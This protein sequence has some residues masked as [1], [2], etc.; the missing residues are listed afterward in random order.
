M[1]DRLRRR[2]RKL[3]GRGAGIDDYGVAALGGLVKV[4]VRRN[5]AIGSASRIVGRAAAGGTRRVRA[6]RAGT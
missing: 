2:L 5:L 3:G 6:G 4:H 1:A